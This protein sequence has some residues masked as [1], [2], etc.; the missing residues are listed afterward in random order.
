MG[1]FA[2]RPPPV[3]PGWNSFQDQTQRHWPDDSYAVDPSV[4]KYFPPHL[5]DEADFRR[6][7]VRLQR[8]SKGEQDP[9]FQ[10]GLFALIAECSTPAGNEEVGRESDESAGRC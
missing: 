2:P 7:V 10:A 6:Q 1:K 8:T 4:E 3:Q 9:Q 5:A